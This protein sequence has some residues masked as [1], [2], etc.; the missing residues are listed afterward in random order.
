[1]MKIEITISITIFSKNQ[2]RIRHFLPLQ[3][4]L[5]TIQRFSI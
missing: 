1:L 3:I 4:T 2:S 5:Q